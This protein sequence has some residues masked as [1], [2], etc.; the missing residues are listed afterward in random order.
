MNKRCSIFEEVAWGT[1]AAFLRL[2]DE[3]RKLSPSFTPHGLKTENKQA[4][5][6]KGALEGA[7]GVKLQQQLVYP[8]MAARMSTLPF[9]SHLLPYHQQFLVHIPSWSTTVYT[10]VFYHYEYYNYIFL[11]FISS[12]ADTLLCV[13]Q[14][15]PKETIQ[16]RRGEAAAGTSCASATVSSIYILSE[17][18]SQLPS[19]PKQHYEACYFSAFSPLASVVELKKK[20]K[21]APQYDMFHSDDSCFACATVTDIIDFKTFVENFEAFAHVGQLP[22]QRGTVCVCVQERWREEEENRER[23]RVRVCDSQFSAPHHCYC[24]PLFKCHNRTCCAASNY[25]SKAPESL[26]C[27]V[28]AAFNTINC[29]AFWWEKN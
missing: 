15:K 7:C 11:L 21:C 24:F 18:N 13:S 4:V 8:G 19:A 1:S 9:T 3:D 26:L 16:R 17:N 29:L 12:A 25:A 22:G 14:Q 28:C 23:E 6:N 20:K 27:L 5:K 10:H 2:S